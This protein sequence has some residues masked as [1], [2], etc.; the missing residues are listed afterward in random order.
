MKDKSIIAAI[1]CTAANGEKLPICIVGKPNKPACF[2][3]VPILPMP[4][5]NQYNA[6]FDRNVT[7]LWINNV[8]WPWD[9]KHCGDVTFIIL[10]HN[11]TSY[12]M[13]L[14]QLP[15]NLNILFLPPNVTNL[16]QPTYIWMIAALKFGYNSL[17]IHSILLIFD[18]PGG[19]DEA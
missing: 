15:N 8:F 18:K 17:Y 11:C 7:M 3:L 4:Y 19:F 13:D 16:H 6:W 10:I 5:T 12:I 14:S 9:L 2:I 1:I